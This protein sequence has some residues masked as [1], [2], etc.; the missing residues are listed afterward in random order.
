[1]D[2][3]PTPHAY[4]RY[5]PIMTINI[6]ENRC[7]YI[8]VNILGT[9]VRGLLDSGA[10]ASIVSDP[11]LLNKHRLQ[12]T[13]SNLKIMTADGTPHDCA[14]VVYIPYTFRG[15]TKVV[16]TLYV[17]N[18]A[19]KLI[20]GNDFWK[21]FKITPAL[22]ENGNLT[23]L[24]INCAGTDSM[25]LDC[26]E[27]YFA[28]EGVEINLVLEQTT[29]IIKPDIIE[30]ASLDLPSVEKPT[31]LELSQISTEH[32]LAPGERKELLDIVEVLKGDGK[33][34]RTNVLQHRIDILEGE[35]PKR[36]PRYRWSPAIEK[37]MEKE[38]QRMRELD[39]IEESTS[40]WCNPLLPVKN[41]MENGDYAWTAGE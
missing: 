40:D 20:L 34:G 18:L 8:T 26:V 22:E 10:A 16:P 30:D 33:L 37:E 1:M 38:I 9:D 28:D 7:P 23:R 41:Q 32:E 6:K 36:P 11:N 24:E 39:V 5:P 29:N 21:T 13:P 12:R 35:R 19:K 14:S 31:K 15:Y 25:N 27:Q 2:Q 17:P 4:Q 3:T